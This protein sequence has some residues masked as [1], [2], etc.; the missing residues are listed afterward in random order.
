MPS[1]NDRSSVKAHA[2]ALAS[3]APAAPPRAAVPPQSDPPPSARM[4][5]LEAVMR[6]NNQRLFR[7]ARSVLRNDADA[8]EVL[9]EVY[10]AAFSS[11]PTEQPSDVSAWLISVTFRRCIDRVRANVRRGRLGHEVPNGGVTTLPQSPEHLASQHDVLRRL[12]RAVDSLP[13]GLRLVFMLRDVQGL[14]GTDTAN[15]L[16]IAEPAVRVRLNRARARLRLA[17]GATSFSDLNQTFEFGSSR[18]D[19]L[20]ASVLDRVGPS[21]ASVRA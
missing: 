18:C 6:H 20:V 21:A 15:A 2:Y 13:V 10:L 19:R 3:E 12:E 8:E 14:S 16:R 4:S 17:L 11:W 1:P 9:Q 5:E 7:V